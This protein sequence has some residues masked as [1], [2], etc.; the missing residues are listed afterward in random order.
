MV[1]F[2]A[3]IIAL[4]DIIRTFVPLQK[5]D[6]TPKAKLNTAMSA[7]EANEQLDELN[8]KLA[9][10]DKFNV[11]QQS[12]GAN[13]NIA[14]TEAL[15]RLLEEQVALYDDELSSAMKNMKNEAVELAKKIKDV[16]AIS[17]I[18]ISVWSVAKMVSIIQTL[19]LLKKAL[20]SF[21]GTVGSLNKGLSSTN[22]LL[23]SGILFAFY[24]MYEA[25]QAGDTATA[26]IAGTI[27]IV[28]VGALIK[29]NFQAKKTQIELLKTTNAITGVHYAMLA[30][31]TVFMAG[32]LSTLLSSEMSA[33]D[34][35][36]HT[37]I[38]LAA[39][40]TAA[41]IAMAFFK[42]NWAEALGIAA[43][44]AGGYF[45][46]A[47]MSAHADG[48]YSN[49]NLIMTHENGKREWVGKA[50]GSS[51]IVN[52]TQMSDIMEM[53]V[54]KGVYNALSARSAMGGNVPTNETIVVKIGEE[55]VFNAVRKTA[56]RQGRDFAN[57]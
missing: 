53:A 40:I 6:E 2:N 1:L 4:T 26:T 12:N 47:S 44:V 45:S 7:E 18:L 50:A 13:E 30:T 37:F 5:N 36:T 8:G 46:I 27:G 24:K 3:F 10:F 14:L 9:S 51:A 52:D 29:F 17:V 57:V 21:T 15:N 35:L 41:A 25:I 33:G 49:A 32:G 42:Q 39:A 20:A 54:A 56:R 48:G 22:L 43:T 23:V 19:N 11:L 16:V 34:K 55:A 38:G 28:L 31:S